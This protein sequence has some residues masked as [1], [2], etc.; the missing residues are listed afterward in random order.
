MKNRRPQEEERR[1]EKESAGENKRGFVRVNIGE[2]A[3]K[4]RNA[5]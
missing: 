3:G 1:S 2:N 4:E 5:E